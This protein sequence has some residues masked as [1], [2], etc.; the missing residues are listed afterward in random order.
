M[1]L[2]R[3]PWP[4]PL[5]ATQTQP[6]TKT[7]T[8]TQTLY[9]RVSVNTNPDDDAHALALR[10]EGEDLQ[11]EIGEDLPRGCLQLQ[12][13]QVAVHQR[14]AHALCPA[15]QGHLNNNT[16]TDLPAIIL[17]SNWKSI[18]IFVSLLVLEKM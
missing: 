18:Y 2:T 11:D 14:Q 9:Y 4:G 1:T 16:E 8:H 10:G 6:H 5:R 13:G 17:W 3:S 7:V 15:H 12:G